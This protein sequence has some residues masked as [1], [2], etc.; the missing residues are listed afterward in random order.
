MSAGTGRALVAACA[1]GAIALL[2][3]CG[4]AAADR[5]T[6]GPVES[7]SESAPPEMMPSHPSPSSSSTPLPARFRGT[8]SALPADLEAQMRG[9]TWHPGCPLAIGRL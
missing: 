6:D 2:T 1:V 4:A 8:V 9:T 5:S 3:A 7:P